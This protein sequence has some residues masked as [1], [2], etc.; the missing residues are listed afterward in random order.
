MAPTQ[1]LSSFDSFI[2]AG[3]QKK[4]NEE[5]AKEIFGKGRRSSTPSA[6]RVSSKA[7]GSLASRVTK[8]TQPAR[9]ASS[10][11]LSK[12]FKR[13]QANNAVS[14]DDLFEHII[15]SNRQSR[16]QEVGSGFSI[17]GLAGP[18]V[19]VGRNFAPGT[20]AADIQSAMESVG[21][22][23]QSCTIVS[24]SP[25]VTA[26]MVFPDKAN[27]DAVIAAFDNQKADGRILRLFLKKGPAT[28]VSAPARQTAPAKSNPPAYSESSYE[29]GSDFAPDPKLTSRAEPEIQD[30]SFGFNNQNDEMVVDVEPEVKQ[31]ERHDELRD[32]R[33]D[34]R[35]EDRREDRR[36]HE[37][38]ARPYYFDSRGD[39]PSNG[40]S[41]SYN[42]DQ[43]RDYPRGPR[44]D[45]RG[46][47][48]RGN[49]N[50]RGLY[51]DGLYP[52]PRGRGFR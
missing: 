38:D 33:R 24:A 21:G 47:S 2:Q 34:D 18:A 28:N 5:L 45:F 43:G 10:S 52:Q 15:Q 27:A 39:R 11:T 41:G 31:D 1:A 30:G 49:R 35:R 13:T 29:R 19:V 36:D 51:S 9:A 26:E 20:T 6:N 44:N 37:R 4:K 17:R 8:P 46:Y 3:R 42:R 14:K 12:N 50:D 25:T 40:N 16:L 32:E 7:A 23:M 48:G 22:E